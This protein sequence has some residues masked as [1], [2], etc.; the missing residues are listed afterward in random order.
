MTKL[1]KTKTGLIFSVALLIVFGLVFSFSSPAKAQESETL[2]IGNTIWGMYGSWEH[3]YIQAG[4]WYASDHNMMFSTSN[5]LMKAEKQVKDIQHFIDLDM[6]GIIVGPVSSTAPAG[7]VEDAKEA[8]IPVITANS[9][10]DT[11]AV[12][13][14]VSYGNKNATAALA[15]EVVKYLKNEVKPV[16]KVSGTV[17]HLQGSLEMSIGRQRSAGVF[18]VFEGKEN[19]KTDKYPDL[20]HIVQKTNFQKQPG[21]TKTY[22]VLQAERGK[23]DAIVGNSTSCR[24]AAE[25]LKK[26]GIE[27]G[28]VFIAAHGGTPPDV[29]MVKDGWFQR[30]Y[31]QPTHFYLPIALHYLKL[32]NE[33]GEGALP[34]IGETVTEEDLEISGRKH[35]GVNIWAS[36]SWAPAKI[37]ESY[38]HRWFKTSGRL[39][40]PENVDDPT[41]WGNLFGQ[42]AA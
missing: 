26:Y 42:A 24:G 40:T 10:V 25:A 7:A 13:M 30:A 34:E 4:R 3:A 41:L 15:E 8:G 29:D 38:G 28:E 27:K 39:I 35:L 18:E 5:A 21:F 20:R 36:S 14:S 37:Q 11:P 2:K 9:D 31:A 16:G 22:N 32:A 6:D 23:I 12:S 1:T 17:L 33:E 19:K